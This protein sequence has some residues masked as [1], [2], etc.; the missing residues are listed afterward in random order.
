MKKIAFLLSLIMLFTCLTGC[1]STSGE[2]AYVESVSMICGIGPVGMA[3]RFSGVVSAQGETKIKKNDSMSIDEIKVSVGDVVTKDQE[4]FTYDNSSTTLS[5]EQAQLELEQL[6]N[7]LASKQQEKTQLET[8]KANASADE[9]LQYNLEI[10]EVTASINETQYS[11]SAKQKSISTLQSS[12][13]ETSVKSPVDGVISS[14]NEN[15]GYDSSGNVLPFMTITESGSYQ[16]KAYVNEQNIAA[17]SEGESV[18]IRSRADDTVWTGK[19]SSIDT[20]NPVQNTNYYSDDTQVSS[21]YPFY[22]Q[23]DS[24]DGL[25]LGQHVYVEPD[26]GQTE[27]AEAGVISLPSY[28]IN[29][30]DGGA[31]VWAQGNNGK[32]EKR[33][34]TLG[35]YDENADTYVI[36]KGLELD[37][38][39]AFPDDTLKAG[40]SCTT[41]DETNFEADGS[42]YDGAVEDIVTTE[43]LG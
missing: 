1:G 26:I 12:I 41:Y 11:I 33:S 15:S 19:I 2:E 38:Y 27:E 42:T 10:R 23:L 9:Q 6:Q 18:V 30:A 3:D 17:L 5:I 35:D 32:L 24:T 37:D 4:L 39:I 14:I 22:V 40:M 7:I 16:V 34:I 21:K 20:E 31:W 36:E 28:Y 13:K 29:D 43:E 8:D 25:M